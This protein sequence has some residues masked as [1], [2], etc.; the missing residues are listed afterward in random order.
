MIKNRRVVAVH[1][2]QAHDTRHTPCLESYFSKL[3]RCL[4]RVRSGGGPF[5]GDHP[6]GGPHPFQ[7]PHHAAQRIHSSHHH[8][9]FAKRKKKRKQINKSRPPLS[10]S[11]S[12]LVSRSLRSRRLLRLRLRRPLLLSPRRRR[13]QPPRGS[14][15]PY[16]PFCSDGFCEGNVGLPIWSGLW[17][18]LFLAGGSSGWFVCL[19]FSISLML[20][21]IDS[22]GCSVL[23]TQVENRGGGGFGSKRSR[24]DGEILGGIPL[25]LLLPG[26]G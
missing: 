26:F 19:G 23:S 6:P 10:L 22:G 18:G 16:L 24:N 12:P 25:L 3:R 7:K 9:P 20:V 1:N 8:A 4:P 2:S 17:F 21:L 14:G 15:G 5:V 11:L 13:R